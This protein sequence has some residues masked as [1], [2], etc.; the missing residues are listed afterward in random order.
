MLTVPSVTTE[1]RFVG[2]G[3]CC[4]AS[5]AGIDTTAAATHLSVRCMRSL[6]DAPR[7]NGGHARSRQGGA[8]LESAQATGGPL[9]KGR[10]CCRAA[11]TTT[12]GGR[13][14]TTSGSSVA[15]ATETAGTGIAAGDVLEQCERQLQCSPFCVGA[16]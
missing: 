13:S 1:S 3:V 4:A 7:G 2:G 16:D 12:V 14:G 8:E 5:T 6:G 15:D 11:R 10:T 9:A